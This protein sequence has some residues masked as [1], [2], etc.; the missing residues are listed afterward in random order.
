MYLSR[1]NVK[2]G[3]M[4]V[5][6]GQETTLVKM[7]KMGALANLE[8]RICWKKMV[9]TPLYEHPSRHR[10]ASFARASAFIP[11][12]SGLRT[13]KNVRKLTK[14]YKNCIETVKNFSTWLVARPS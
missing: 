2:I 9:K 10:R 6:D 3:N 8:L 11:I 5:G 4:I 13:D 12:P 1:Q 14:I 7:G